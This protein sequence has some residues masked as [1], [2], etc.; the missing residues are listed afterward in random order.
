MAEV[1]RVLKS[2]KIAIGLGIFVFFS[3]IAIIGPSIAPYHDP[4]KLTGLPWQQPSA[5]HWLGTTQQGQDVYSQLL[6]GTRSTLLISLISG[7]IATVLSV[8]IGVAAGFY[9]GLADNFL[10]MLANIFLVLPALPFLIVI[11]SYLPSGGKSNSTLLAVIIS[12]T[13]WAW[14][15]RVLRAQTLSMRQRD[16]VDAARISG[17]RSWRII[18]FEIV[19]NL[20]PIIA[21]SFVFTV[22]YAMGTY[23]SL[24]FIGAIDPNNPWSWGSM[25]FWAQSNTAA[26]VGG[27]YWFAAPGVC[28][29]LLGTSLVLLNFGI[30]EFINPRLRAA[31]LS[32]KGLRA[33]G[34][35]SR[36]TMGLTPVVRTRPAAAATIIEE[37]V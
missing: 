25:L 17:E 27:W 22:L 10:S 33:A 14:G 24:S 23:V 1:L 29:A 35:R 15:A 28:V 12:L 4:L 16:F 21:A 36:N 8:L 7:A 2:P 6:I 32:R 18:V 31:G 37:T 30:D 34:V 3:L 5:K 9:G 19:P 20:V 26:Q 11:N 13:G